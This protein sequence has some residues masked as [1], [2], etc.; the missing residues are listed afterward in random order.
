[1]KPFLHYCKHITISL[2]MACG[3][4]N[5]H[6]QN[7]PEDEALIKEMIGY[8]YPE[9]VSG[10]LLDRYASAQANGFLS[11]I[12]EFADKELSDN[13]KNNVRL[14]YFTL[15]R[16]EFNYQKQ[17]DFIYRNE[18]DFID[19]DSL[20]KAVK[21]ARTKEGRELI[22]SMNGF[23]YPGAQSIY[24]MLEMEGDTIDFDFKFEKFTKAFPNIKLNLK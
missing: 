7:T 12:E 17:V 22:H 18:R 3:I 5:A 16:K 24:S 1:M 14:F 2:I 11:F 6:A 19:M 4:N 20:Q 13:E 23:A 21:L 9:L 15:I 10:A 8:G